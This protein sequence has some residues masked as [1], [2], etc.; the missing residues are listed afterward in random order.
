MSPAVRTP[1]LCGLTRV[2]SACAGPCF[3]AASHALVACLVP[4]AAVCAGVG[5]SCCSVWS[6]GAARACSTTGR[7]GSGCPSWSYGKGV[8]VCVC[9]CVCVCVCVCNHGSLSSHTTRVCDPNHHS[10]LLVGPAWSEL[11][12]VQWVSSSYVSVWHLPGASQPSAAA[13]L[14]VAV[15]L[16]SSCEHTTRRPSR[17][18]CADVPGRR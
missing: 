15:Q 16:H 1:N 3:H 4:C 2:L 5:W 17:R 11:I 13:V 18:R 12:G 7:N 6:G 10:P 14:G 9:L 8:C